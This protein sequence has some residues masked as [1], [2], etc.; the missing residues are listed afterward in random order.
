MDQTMITQKCA[1]PF[2]YETVERFLVII[3]FDDEAR[4]VSAEV[5]A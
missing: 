3:P 1:R 5:G 2:P 4:L